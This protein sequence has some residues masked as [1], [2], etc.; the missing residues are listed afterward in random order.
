MVERSEKN[1]NPSGEMIRTL[2]KALELTQVEM[3]EIFGVSRR[4]I[5]RWEKGD[6]EPRLTLGQVRIFIQLMQKAGFN[7]E[8]LP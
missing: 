7:W 6:D 4:A 2:R 3:A 8:M 5:Q 1:S